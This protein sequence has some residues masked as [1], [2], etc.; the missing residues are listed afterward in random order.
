MNITG[1]T[2][3]TGLFGYPVEHSLSPSMHNAAF[4]H[5]GLDC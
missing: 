2:R 1:K 5:L 4:K 3:I